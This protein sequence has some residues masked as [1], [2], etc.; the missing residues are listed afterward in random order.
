VFSAVIDNTALVYVTQLHD[1]RSFFDQFKNIFHTLYIPMSVKNEYEKGLSLE[2]NRSW[3]LDRL[4]PDQGF[5][6]LCTS[7]DSFTLLLVDRFKGMDKGES[8]SYAQFKKISAQLIISDDKA[9]AKALGKLDPGIKVYTTLHLICWLDILNYL[10][11]EWNSIIKAIHPIRPFRSAELRSAYEDILR[12]LGIKLSKNTLDEK[13]SL[14][15]I[16][17][18]AK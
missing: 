11:V 14:K 15:A 2:P 6:R 16:L 17:A 18:Q 3:L 12:K 9:F 1:K 7:Y 13:C 4:K 5:F 10:L 8:E